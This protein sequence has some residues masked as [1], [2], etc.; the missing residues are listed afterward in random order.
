M[1]EFAG[2]PSVQELVEMSDEELLRAYFSLGGRLS[3]GGFTD[4]W[5]D[6][7]PKAPLTISLFCFYRSAQIGR[8]CW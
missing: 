6:D 4:P 8:K 5:P 1:I 2:I 3:P 7:S